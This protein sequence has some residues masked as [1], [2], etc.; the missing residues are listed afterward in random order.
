M[1][2][3]SVEM[4]PQH[5]CHQ[6]LMQV[7]LQGWRSCFCLWSWLVYSCANT[8]GKSGILCSLDKEKARRRRTFQRIYKWF[9]I[10]TSLQADSNQQARPL[11]MKTWQVVLLNRP[12]A[13]RTKA[14]KAFIVSN[15]WF[16][17]ETSVCRP[18]LFHIFRPIWRK[19]WGK[20]VISES[21]AEE[22]WKETGDETLRGEF[23]YF[24]KSCCVTCTL[25]GRHL[26]LVSYPF[27]SYCLK[28]VNKTCR[29]VSQCWSFSSE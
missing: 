7:C 20:N 21:V 19:H 24:T 4:A 27:D 9:P 22:V 15:L 11:F 12:G 13:Q 28:S 14:G 29:L 6:V 18:D 16:L 17:V 23:P 26:E 10:N 5:V 25:F 3:V 8:T 1:I 2:P